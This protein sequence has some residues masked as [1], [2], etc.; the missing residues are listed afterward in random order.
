MSNF[1]PVRLTFKDPVFGNLHYFNKDQFNPNL[2]KIDKICPRPYTAI[3]I[4]AMGEVIVCCF[5]WLPLVLGNVLENTI[6]EI[7]EGHKAQTLRNSVTDGTY[8]YCNRET[9]HSLVA[10]DKKDLRS[11]DSFRPPDQKLPQIILFSVDPTCNLYCPSCRSEELKQLDTDRHAR[12]MSIV[13]TVLKQIID[14][15]H[16]QKIMIGF[17]GTGEVFHSTIYR[18]IFESESFFSNLEQWPNITFL[19]KT[20]G[21]MMTEKIQKRYAHL[22]K[23]MESISISIDAGNKESY[24]KV[25]LGGHWDLLWKNID[26]LHETCFNPDSLDSQDWSWQLILQED[27]YESIPE[28]IKLARSYTKRIPAVV[29]SPLINWGTFSAEE[30]AK[31]AVWQPTSEKYQHLL[32]ILNLPEVRDYP[33]LVSPISK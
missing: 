6:E 32:E 18:E 31:K 19:F 4:A 15:P 12:A 8:R 11:R 7:W 16:D 26:Y 20:N 14:K 33:R 3:E 1:H 17:D 9:C 29:I 28:L 27:N 23:R 25:R 13:K 21:V 5:D 30:F 2:P 24:D 10:T 22:F